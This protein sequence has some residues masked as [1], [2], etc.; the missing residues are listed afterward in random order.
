MSSNKTKIL[1]LAIIVCIFGLWLYINIAPPPQFKAVFLNIGQGDSSLI[2]LP[3]GGKMLVDCGPDRTILRKLNQ[4]LPFYDRQ[5]DYLLVTHPDLDHYGGCIDV[6]RRY[7]VKNIFING[8]KK[9]KDPN[10]LSWENY[11]EKEGA[12]VFIVE[13][14][15][16]YILSGARLKFFS[17]DPEFINEKTGDNDKSLVFK[18]F[19]NTTTIFFAADMEEK[20]EKELVKKYCEDSAEDCSELKSDYLKVGHHGSDSS[21]GQEFLTAVNPHTGIISV[22]KNNFGHPS[23]RVLRRME[24]EDMEIW[25]TDRRGDIIVK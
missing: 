18:F 25:R 10:F 4:Y 15:I 2:F 11:L 8:A 6:L 13:R 21:S 12:E 23:L 7:D 19:Y 14:P 24:R 3:Q 20:I 22:G 5:I 16:A 1:S 17:P 9:E